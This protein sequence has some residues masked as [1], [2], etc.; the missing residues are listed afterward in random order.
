[1]GKSFLLSSEHFDLPGPASPGCGPSESIH[2]TWTSSFY[3]VIFPFSNLCTLN[4]LL[5]V[6]SYS[7]SLFFL[8]FA[9]L[10]FG[11]CILMWSMR[12]TVL[13]I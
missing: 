12:H 13:W 11:N 4:Y 10:D 8:C 3:Y 7:R 1:M 2:K 5:Y 9:Q 6:D